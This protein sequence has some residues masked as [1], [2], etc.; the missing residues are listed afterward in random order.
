M[1]VADFKQFGRK[2]KKYPKTETPGAKSRY[3]E[4]LIR[5]VNFRDWE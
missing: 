3:M 5:N 1:M 4:W 2:R